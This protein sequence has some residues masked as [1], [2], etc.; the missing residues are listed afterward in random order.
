MGNTQK[1]KKNSSEKGRDQLISVS[2]TDF[3]EL[4]NLGDYRWFYCS[5]ILNW[6]NYETL[7]D[8]EKKILYGI[9]FL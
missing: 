6:G 1:G 5:E 9:F 2:D 4:A 7:S 3:K 8:K